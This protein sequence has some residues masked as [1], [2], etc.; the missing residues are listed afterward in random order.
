[1]SF[2]SKQYLSHQERLLEPGSVIVTGNYRRH[3]EK[4]MT[5]KNKWLDG[6]SDAERAQLAKEWEEEQSKNN[7]RY[8]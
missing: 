7:Y 1:M 8:D 4:T 5:D 6:L 2:N 3:T